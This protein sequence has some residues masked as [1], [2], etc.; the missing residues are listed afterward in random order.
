[1]LKKVL[2][3]MIIALTL[4]ATLAAA[5]VGAAETNLAGVGK[6][7]EITYLSGDVDLDGKVTI[8]DASK[9]QKNA[10][11]IINLSERQYL[12][13]DVVNRSVID[14]RDATAIQKYLAGV[15]LDCT[16]GR[17]M[18]IQVMADEN[19]N[20]YNYDQEE[21]FIGYP[22]EL[23]YEAIEKAIGEKFTE[24]VNEERKA[25]GVGPLATNKVLTEAACLR[26]E[27]IEE[28][29]SH[30]RP[31]GT[32]CYTAIKDQSAFFTMGENV[33]YNGG[34]IYFY[35][36]M[37]S[38]ELA[39]EIDYAAKF[40]FGQFKSSEGHYRNMIYDSFNCS[41]VGV[42]IV[43]GDGYAECYM[44]HMFGGTW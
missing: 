42:N 6:T 10:A 12:G 31:D 26:S 28:H 13:A 36:G 37:S 39:K 1:M 29:F 40:F 18:T 7:V 21:E 27:E 23:D 34:I 43:A 15:S 17:E 3:M 19:G 44:A 9:I 5:T 32:K 38:E 4:M 24:L 30:T 14:I 22:E 16:A 33:A 20:P 25:V 8:K 11:G 2:C 41:G 35:D